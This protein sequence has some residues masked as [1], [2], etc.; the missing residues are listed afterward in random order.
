VLARYDVDG[1]PDTGFRFRHALGN[2]DTNASSLTLAPDGKLIVTGSLDSADNTTSDAFVARFLADGTIDTSFSG[3]G[4][5]VYSTPTNDTSSKAAVQSD[6]KIVALV[7]SVDSGT[8]ALPTYRLIRFKADGTPDPLFGSNG[9]TSFATPSGEIFPID[10]SVTSDGRIVASGGVRMVAFQSVDD[11]AVWRFT[12]QG[13]PDASFAS[14]GLWA[15]AASTTVS[16]E[17]ATFAIAEDGS[18]YGAGQVVSGLVNTTDQLVVHLDGS[19]VLDT[20]FGVGGTAT[21]SNLGMAS[22]AIAIVPDHR[23]LVGGSVGPI[24]GNPT[25]VILRLWR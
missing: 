4:V 25:S 23:L 15:A 11:Q 7:S 6:G 14:A 21:Q 16:D 22:Q 1:Q 24:G 18:Y 12:G 20:G 9:S 3:D 10:L 2:L 5:A 8:F 19:G 17:V 13:A